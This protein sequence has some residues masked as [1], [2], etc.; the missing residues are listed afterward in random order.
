[1]R[2]GVAR[3]LD[4]RESDRLA[5]RS[6]RRKE[7][8]AVKHE[9]RHR[10]RSRAADE[11]ERLAFDELLIVIVSADVEIDT[12]LTQARKELPHA[13]PYA[14]RKVAVI[15]GRD[16]RVMTDDDAPLRRVAE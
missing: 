13:P 4:E 16:D 3:D 15:A 2:D 5:K 6:V 7:R 14:S 12:I 1:D 9:E 11:K 10:I 8:R